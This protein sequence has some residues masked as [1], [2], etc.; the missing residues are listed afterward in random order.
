MHPHLPDYDH[1]LRWQEQWSRCVRWYRKVEAIKQKSFKEEIGADDRDIIFSFFQNCYHLR[2]WLSNTRPDIQ[3]EMEDLFARSPELQACLDICN[4]TKHGALDRPKRD[5]HFNIY[6][7][8][9]Y[10]VKSDETGESPVK[11]RVMFGPDTD[12]KK[13]DI[14]ELADGCARLWNEFLSKRNLL[15]K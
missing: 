9:D 2:D 15:N 6:R 13:W 7:E 8:Y 3:K 5:A 10:L 14:F 11:Y 1:S 12:I 4:G